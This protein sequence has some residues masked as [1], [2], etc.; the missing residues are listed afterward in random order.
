MIDERGV[1]GMVSAAKNSKKLYDDLIELGFDDTEF[2]E[3]WYSPVRAAQE[4]TRVNES[5]REPEEQSESVREPFEAATPRNPALRDGG[6]GRPVITSTLDRSTQDSSTL[7]HS[8]QDT[9]TQEALT[10]LASRKIYRSPESDEWFHRE[11]N[12]DGRTMITSGSR[13]H[14]RRILKK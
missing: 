13:A 6:G 14:R 1:V 3:W 2:P 4:Q 10:L 12:P 9:F 5:D 8:P 11:E 7:V